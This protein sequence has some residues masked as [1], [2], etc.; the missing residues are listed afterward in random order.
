M[1]SILN[2]LREE[3]NLDN[4]IQFKIKNEF[5]EMNKST[6]GDWT[7]F[8]VFGHDLRFDTKK[9]KGYSKEDVEDILKARY[10]NI[11]IY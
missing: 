4:T 11:E 7:L 10:K 2:K 5:Y 1:K 9:L 3:F 6:K 8:T